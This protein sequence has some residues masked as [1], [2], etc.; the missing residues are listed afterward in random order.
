MGE[1]LL[2]EVFRRW[3]HTKRVLKGRVLGDL[4]A[5]PR[6]MTGHWGSGTLFERLSES[7]GQPDVAFGKQDQIPE[8][9]TTVDIDPR[10]EPTHVCD[11]AAMPFQDGEFKFGYWD[12]PYL[13]TTDPEGMVHYTIHA[14]CY[15]EISRVC[16]HRL[17]ILHPIVYPK[18][19]GWHR[20][21]VIG[22][23]FGARKII[24]CLQVMDRDEVV[25][26]TKLEVVG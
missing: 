12:P 11:W 23:T 25:N 18:P 20:V 19:A 10:V 16:S 3:P 21:A 24:R 17:A 26:Q 9:V 14:P 8:G 13:A 15:R 6:P 7:F 22:I 4:W 2:D 1:S 5:L